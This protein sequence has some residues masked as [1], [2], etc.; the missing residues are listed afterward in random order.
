MGSEAETS[1]CPRR[2]GRQFFRLGQGAE[3]GL[4]NEK[5]GESLGFSE[6]ELKGR[7]KVSLLEGALN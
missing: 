1:A 3:F 2:E 4:G 5:V 6:Q 7:L